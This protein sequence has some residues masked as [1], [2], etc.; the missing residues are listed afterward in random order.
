VI[1]RQTILDQMEHLEAQRRQ[2]EDDLKAIRGAN[3]LCRHWLALCDQ[4]DAEKAAKDAEAAGCNG[5]CGQASTV[6]TN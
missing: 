6:G 3:Q 4:Q 1:D 5:H 2:H